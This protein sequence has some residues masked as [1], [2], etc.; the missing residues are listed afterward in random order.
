[1]APGARQPGFAGP[2]AVSQVEQDGDLPYLPVARGPLVEMTTP[3]RGWTQKGPRAV[4]AFPV[5]EQLHRGI[6]RRGA[7]SRFDVERP[8]QASRVSTKA[9]MSLYDVGKRILRDR[10]G[11]SR[12]FGHELAQPIPSPL[13]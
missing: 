13:S 9:M 10:V 1:M 3:F 11:Q 6:Q 7:G 8:Q 2:Q 4:V 5:A 12:G